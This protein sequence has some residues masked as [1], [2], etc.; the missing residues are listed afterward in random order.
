M[1]D[2]EFLTADKDG[3]HSHNKPVKEEC[4]IPVL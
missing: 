3:T 4:L 1:Q 2:S